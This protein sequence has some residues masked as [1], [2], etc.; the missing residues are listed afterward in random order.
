MTIA[1]EYLKIWEKVQENKKRLESCC[2]PHEF[3]PVDDSTPAS[4]VRRQ[5]CI[6]CGGEVDAV[7]AIWYRQGLED[8]K[9]G[10]NNGNS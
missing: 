7:N 10:K 2:V 9:K 8:A 6:H 4:R 5:V 3:K 1:P